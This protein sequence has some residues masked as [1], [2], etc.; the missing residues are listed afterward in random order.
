MGGL[1]RFSVGTGDRF[2]KEGAA[3][4]AAVAALD[5]MGVPVSIVWNKSNREHVIIGTE[6]AD[7][8]AAADAAVAA[9]GWKGSYFVDADHI[10]L[11]TVGRFV[12]HCDFFTIDVADFIGKESDH[13]DVESFVAKH[14]ALVG[15]IPIAGLSGPLTL[16]EQSIRGAATKYLKAVR[17]AGAVYR[18]VKEKKGATSFVVEVSMD[19]TAEPQSPAELL[20][21]LAAIADECIPVDTVA[22]KFSGRFNK[23]VEY[24]GN[25]EA[26]E[27]EFEDDVRV[28]S[29]AIGAFSLHQGLK[30][31]VHSGSDKFALYPRI[32][33]VL[34]KTGAGVHL[35]TAG[36]T[37]LEE[38]IGIAEA[39][40]EGLVIAKEVYRSALDHFD[41][42]VAPYA[43]VVDI[44]KASLPSADTV[45]GWSGSQFADALRHDQGNPSYNLNLRQLLHVG[46]K[47]AAK[48]GDRYLDVLASCRESVE[49]NVTTNLLERHLKPLFLGL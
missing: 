37:W 39:G 21:I 42:L 16:S 27:R 26:F 29:W 45:D 13:A 8:R 36:T 28:L 41:E 12:D 35:K 25:P 6:P 9:L 20:V 5:A 34:K 40:G 2:G 33:R 4:L 22:P 49:R 38:L 30:L 10:G 3:Q 19:E 24:V 23:G 18:T 7:Q 32:A 31:S 14:G 43:E 17:E 46:Y 47:V 48:M 15:T 11:K 1:G 44:D